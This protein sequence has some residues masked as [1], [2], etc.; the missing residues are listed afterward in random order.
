VFVPVVVVAAGQFPMAF[1]NYK[2]KLGAAEVAVTEHVHAADAITIKVRVADTITPL[3]LT[4]FPVV[5]TQFVLL[6]QL[7]AVA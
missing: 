4:Q 6:E 1:I 7:P 3:R 2:L 5:Y